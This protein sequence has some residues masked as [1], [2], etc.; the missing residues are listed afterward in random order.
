MERCRIA[1]ASIHHG[2][3]RPSFITKCDWTSR[4]N[5]NEG[6]VVGWDSITQSS[7]GVSRCADVAI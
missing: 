6:R 3:M 1:F 4:R 5:E 7:S 2:A